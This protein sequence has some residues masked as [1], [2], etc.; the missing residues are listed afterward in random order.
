MNVP[1]RSLSLSTVC[2]A[3]LSWAARPAGQQSHHHALS[4]LLSTLFQMFFPRHAG[5]AAEQEMKYFSSLT[6]DYY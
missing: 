1:F 4:R 2:I 3:P 6:K 5:C